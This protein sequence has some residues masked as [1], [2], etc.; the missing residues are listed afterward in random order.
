MVPAMSRV[1]WLRVCFPAVMLILVNDACGQTPPVADLDA[2]F[3]RG[4][5]GWTL[6]SGEFAVATDKVLGKPVL[7]AGKDLLVLEKG[8]VWPAV[9]FRALVRLKTDVAASAA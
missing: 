3:G 7:T 9:T 4:G 8:P 5:H 6:V 2:I 1:C